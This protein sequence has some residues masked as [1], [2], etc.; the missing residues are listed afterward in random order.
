[1]HNY[2]CY[3]F[4]HGLGRTDFYILN[5]PELSFREIVQK[6]LLSAVSGSF[7]TEMLEAAKTEVN[8]T[9][10]IKPDKAKTEITKSE[11][12]KTEIIKSE[13]V[14]TEITMLK[15]SVKSEIVKSEES[16]LEEPTK[17]EKVNSEVKLESGEPQENEV[18]NVEI[19]ESI[20]SE[21]N[22]SL[23][24]AI[25]VLEKS[26]EN[27]N[28]VV[29]KEASEE[30]PEPM[31]MNH[32]ENTK[33]DINYDNCKQETSDTEMV[34]SNCK[35]LESTDQQNDKEKLETV[36]VE[37]QHI[38]IQNTDTDQL[39]INKS[40]NK[41]SN[42][43]DS[44]VI[45][46]NNEAKNVISGIPS[47]ESSKT[48]A[49]EIESLVKSKECSASVE[50]VDRLKAMFPELEVVH[51]DVSTPTVDKLPTHKPLQQIDQTIAHLLVT[52]YQNPI[53]WPKVKLSL[54]YNY[55]FFS[56]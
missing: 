32:Q 17:T 38:G 1:M 41:T 5:D 25:S 18:T 22:E 37:D 39:K 27:E 49:K 56:C 7:T 14:I 47:D 48:D 2:I 28:N 50:S 3:Y 44:Q 51:K 31:K 42:D 6:N 21:K 19:N 36:I 35:L 23:S 9:E 54:Y 11:I 10:V 43:V 53:K 20:T 55:L 33:L 16:N 46:V 4:R 30:N 12:A 26:Q 24:T 15:D 40:E 52:S 45:S 8:K 29:E 34:Q 13:T